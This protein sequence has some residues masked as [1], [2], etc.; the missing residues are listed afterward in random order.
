MLLLGS[1]LLFAGVTMLM[2]R[3]EHAY[4]PRPELKRRLAIGVPCGGASGLLGGLVG[5]G[6]G[7]FLSPL[8]HRLRL[9]QPKVIAATASLF[10]LVNSAAGLVGQTIKLGGTAHFQNMAQFLPLFLAVFAG[11]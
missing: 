2:D 1:A 10:I 9:A 4:F 11:G 8:L 6:G 5:I 3:I 7:I